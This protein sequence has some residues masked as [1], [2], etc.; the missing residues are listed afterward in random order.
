MDHKERIAEIKRKIL[1][2]TNSSEAI[3]LELKKM[4]ESMNSLETLLAG[5][6]AIE[7]I[8]KNDEVV[9]LL[10][11]LNK[12]IERIAEIKINFKEMPAPRV[13]MPSKI[14]IANI[15]D[16][17]PDNVKVDWENAP[18]PEKINF[19]PIKD[20]FTSIRNLIEPVI[21]KIIQYITE[22]DK[23]EI[24]KTSLIEYYGKR[25]VTYTLDRDNKDKIR[26]VVRNES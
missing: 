23:I 10:S 22:P 21:S 19:N 9:G 18:I 25:T 14:E 15:S 8:S 4:N 24:T 5:I 13:V 11:E 6:Q 17:K 7:D 3:L 26:S 12:K 16:L 20:V 2:K 1:E